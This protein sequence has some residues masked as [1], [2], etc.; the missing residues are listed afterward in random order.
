METT[1][2]MALRWKWRTL[3]VCFNIKKKGQ[4]NSPSSSSNI[5]VVV[6]RRGNHRVSERPRP[7]PPRCVL[8]N[9][10]LSIACLDGK[11]KKEHLITLIMWSDMHVRVRRTHKRCGNVDAI[12][13]NVEMPKRRRRSARI[14][15]KKS[16]LVCYKLYIQT[17]HHLI[18]LRFIAKANSRGGGGG[19][20]VN[21]WCPSRRQKWTHE[22]EERYFFQI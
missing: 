14:I 17:H 15:R 12:V 19:D 4:L 3:E 21:S 18:H 5:H 9:P 1:R 16:G 6:A 7:P 11:R 8:G 10:Q 22:K 13:S 2:E 20:R